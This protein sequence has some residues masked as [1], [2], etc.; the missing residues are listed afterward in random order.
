MTNYSERVVAIQR[1]DAELYRKRGFKRGR[2]HQRLIGPY[3]CVSRS[4]YFEIIKL[5]PP[6]TYNTEI[7]EDLYTQGLVYALKRLRRCDQIR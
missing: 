2:I 3:F 6:D 7:A 1:L 4:R 5:R